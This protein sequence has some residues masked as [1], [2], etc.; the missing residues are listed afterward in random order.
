[1]FGFREIHEINEETI[2]AQKEQRKVI[3]EMADVLIGSDE[4]AERYAHKS[5]SI[6]DED[7]IDPDKL[8]GAA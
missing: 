1:M 3:D 7:A 8:I 6:E 5:K 4:W 2:R